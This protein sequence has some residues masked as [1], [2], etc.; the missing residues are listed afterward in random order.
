MAQ[1]GTIDPVTAASGGPRG[2][3]NCGAGNPATA[4]FC[5]QCGKGLP[6][7]NGGAPGS[8]NALLDSARQ[9]VLLGHWEDAA[10]AAEA[11]LALDP[12]SAEAHHIAAQARL[13]QGKAS[14]ALHH[15][16]RAVELDG[17][18]AEYQATLAQAMHG[19]GSASTITSPAVLASAAALAVIALVIVL[20]FTGKPKPKAA[21]APTPSA[22]PSGPASPFAQ[23]PS[24]AAYPQPA[25]PSGVDY[26]GPRVPARTTP[27][28]PP[29][30][31]T[32]NPA[33]R[34]AESVAGGALPDTTGLAPAPVD[35]SA[36]QK[37]A[38]PAPPSQPAAAAPS[39]PAQ[40]APRA[41]AQ[42]IA[43]IVPPLAQAQSQHGAVAP[44]PPASNSI[45]GPAPAAR[46]PAAVE[47]T[48]T[49][50][51]SQPA[52]QAPARTTVTPQQQYV[53]RDYGAAAQ[54]YQRQIEAG[55]ATGAKY[56]QLGLSYERLGDRQKAAQA[57]QNAI[58]AYKA[59]LQAGQDPEVAS[60]GLRSTQRAL[61]MLQG[62]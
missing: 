56:Q 42:H 61:N 20:A 26:D 6:P 53:E 43:P 44:P 35:T 2:C 37:F 16:E 58:A 48:H 31:A 45:F 10:L 24:G 47:P 15:A 5:A 7:L 1:P 28:G 4:R 59:Q 57:Y 23:P 25:R 9:H 52:Q 17:G 38:P 39:P 36:L 19:G 21:P 13:K 51:P 50:T 34:G 41:P 40:T 14:G 3:S 62:R 54:G 12:D 49:A 60:R 11:A 55:H 32:P 29:A 33:R 8:V 18:N 46:Q 22:T 30:L 27:P